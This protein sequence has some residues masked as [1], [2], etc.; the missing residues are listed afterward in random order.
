MEKQERLA[1]A[2][3]TVVGM[4]LLAQNRMDE[5]RKRFEA[6]L[7]RDPKA[8]AAANNLAW[9]YAETGGDLDRALRLATSARQAVPDEPQIADTIGWIYYKKNLPLLA[10][11]EFEKAIALDPANAAFHHHLGLALIA[12]GQSAKGTAALQRALTVQPN[13]PAADEVR[14]LLAKHR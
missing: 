13:Y 9:I 5:A 4:I 6:V 11:P 10:V 7:D 12:G 2:S 1:T 14:Q 3:G 8:A